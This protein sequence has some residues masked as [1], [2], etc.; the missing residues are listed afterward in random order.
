MTQ[1]SVEWPTSVTN[2]PGS[3]RGSFL[4]KPTT[5]ILKRDTFHGT[6]WHYYHHC[7][8]FYYYCCCDCRVLTREIRY[9]IKQSVSLPYTEK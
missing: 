9:N 4:T 1:G 8:Y 2:S 5:K 6:V 3:I 7:H